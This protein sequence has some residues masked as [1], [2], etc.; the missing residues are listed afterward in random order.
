MSN[1]H[2]IKVLREYM[3]TADIPSEVYVVLAWVIGKLYK[4]LDQ[5][6]GRL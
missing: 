4:E 1:E 6:Q 2:M 3:N 5:E